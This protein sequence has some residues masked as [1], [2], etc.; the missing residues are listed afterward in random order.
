MSHLRDL[1]R[2]LT[3][4]TEGLDAQALLARAQA[5]FGARLALASSMSA[6]DQV[7]THM[8]TT[9]P[10]PV[11]IFTL[12]TGRLPQATHDLIARTRERLAVTIEV[13]FPE[14]ADVES[15]VADDGI[16]GFRNSVD[17]RKRCCYAR[18]VLPLR[19]ALTD[20]DAWITGLRAQQSLTRHELP[21]VEWDAANEKIKINPL[22]DWSTEQVWDYIRTN[23]LPYNEL[24]DRGYPS[25]GCE[26][27]TRAVAPDED[28]RAG[29]WWWEQPEHKECGLHL[30]PK[31]DNNP[32]ES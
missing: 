14:R 7:V 29:R 21:R 5:T 30:G 25:I 9:L 19:R 32:T 16:N 15:L 28:I 17:A 8:L 2:Q 11:R 18:K 23:D 12:D 20:T 26:P 10:K 4:D 22:A 13:F 31:D 27:C 6:E 24:H 1:V 3:D